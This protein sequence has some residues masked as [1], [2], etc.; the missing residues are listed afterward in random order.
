[1]KIA[2]NI[3]II[4]SILL[5]LFM[6]FTS[7]SAIG[8]FIKNIFGQETGEAINK[9]VAVESTSESF[10]DRPEKEIIPIG[11]PTCVPKTET[12]NNL[13]DDCD[14]LID[15]DDVCVVVDNPPTQIQT[16]E[17]IDP[18]GVNF[19]VSS[20]LTFDEKLFS[21]YCE[22]NSVID[23][24]CPEEVQSSNFIGNIIRIIGNV[25][26]T[27]YP[28]K[29]SKN[30]LDYGAKFVCKDGACAD[31]LECKEGATK[32]CGTD[33]GECSSGVQN[34]V[35]GSWF[36]QCT[37]YIG[38]TPEIC[39]ELDNDCNSLVDEDLDCENIP[40][41]VTANIARPPD[42][43]STTQPLNC[44]DSDNGITPGIAGWV[45][46]LNATLYPDMII[47]NWPNPLPGR[48][49]SDYC[50]FCNPNNPSAGTCVKDY[51]CRNDGTTTDVNTFRNDKPFTGNVISSGGGTTTPTID[52]PEGDLFKL[53]GCE[54]GCLSGRCL[55][56]PVETVIDKG[57]YVWMSP[58]TKEGFIRFT[59]SAF[60]NTLG[61][62]EVSLKI[63]A[64]DNK[65]NQVLGY[66]EK[67]NCENKS[68]CRAPNN[69]LY[70][71]TFDMIP[72]AINA[73][74][75]LW[76][77]SCTA[78]GNG[79]SDTDTLLIRTDDCS[80]SFCPPLR[81]LMLYPIYGTDSFIL[82]YYANANSEELRNLQLK[83]LKKTSEATSYTEY[84]NF[85]INCKHDI[86]TF[87]GIY[88]GKG[89]YKVTTTLFDHN[90]YSYSNEK[91]IEI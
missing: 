79:Y 70:G 71:Y 15:E 50:T 76:S 59:C 21:D 49:Y 57:T 90:K 11:K 38:A 16:H 82:E 67:I 41:N 61:V 72:G 83:I 64:F 32:P 80:I 1:M 19:L 48:I 3:L 42:N 26:V 8:G 66:E 60:S 69:T 85:D 27:G 28:I 36:N 33:I 86:C 14:T 45:A 29:N 58:V 44:Y 81:N 47:A 4:F 22:G 62:E 51:Y 25:I 63:N 6:G 55:E 54:Y 20:S 31:N 68:S 53:V 46:Y 89:T 23:Y 37:E 7:A 39:D 52:R 35:G 74:P 56:S 65:I 91:N 13:D 75:G 12:C 17:C 78:K 2:T 73:F 24:T 40:G 43:G 84:K 77:F 18:D 10:V 9:Q 34:C 87:Y 5:I 30:C 88:S